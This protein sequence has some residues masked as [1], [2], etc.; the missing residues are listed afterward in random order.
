M[1]EVSLHSMS[2]ESNAQTEMG[3]KKRIDGFTILRYLENVGG[4]ETAQEQ[5]KSKTLIFNSSPVSPKG[6]V[7]SA[8]IGQPLAYS[9]AGGELNFRN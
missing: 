7:L 4:L 3:Q 6:D 9:S 5:M 8:V 1:D 2:L